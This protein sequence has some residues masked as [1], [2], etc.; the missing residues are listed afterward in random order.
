M[1]DDIAIEAMRAEGGSDR[2]Q[3]SL[4]GENGDSSDV[5][6]VRPNS[7]HHQGGRKRKS[8]LDDTSAENIVGGVW[9]AAKAASQEAMKGTFVSGRHIPEEGRDPDDAKITLGKNEIGKSAR[10]REEEDAGSVRFTNAF[11]EPPARPIKLKGNDSKLR[12]DAL[13]EGG[14]Q[15]LSPELRKEG[16]D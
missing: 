16:K 4:S 10:H 12:L 2:D 8:R 6:K 15:T 14:K 13:I 5:A 3:T 7:D 11:R 1:T 9:G